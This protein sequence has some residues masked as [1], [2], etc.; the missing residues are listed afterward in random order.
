MGLFGNKKKKAANLMA[1]GAKAVGTV[2]QV[3]DTGMTVNDNPR[4]K[5]LFRVEPLD[6]SPAFDAEKTKTVS[7]VEIPQAGQRYPVWY[8]VE[9]PS[10]WLYATIADPS[11]RQQIVQLFGPEPFGADGSGV[12]MPA[13]AAAPAPV[14]DDPIAQIERLAK[15]HAAGALSD[16][17]FAAQKAKLL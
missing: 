13:M 1:E 6:G 7:R 9:D 3:Q 10:S 4:V 5:M 17:E 15:L 12:G 11:G 16:E 14:A 8:D 2:V